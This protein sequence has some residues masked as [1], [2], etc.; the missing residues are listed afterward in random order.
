LEALAFFL[1][2]PYETTALLVH[3]LAHRQR[4]LSAKELPLTLFGSPFELAIPT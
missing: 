4:I 3:L 1:T 2:C